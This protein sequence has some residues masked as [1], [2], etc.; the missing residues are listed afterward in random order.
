VTSL[1]DIKNLTTQF[2]THQG[3]V[4]AVNGVS[5]AVGAGEV[6]GIVGE[7]GSGKSVTMLSIMRLVPDP[8]GK[9]VDGQVLFNGRDLLR[10]D[11]A[12]ME[13]VR[14]GEIAMIFQDPMTS[15]NPTWSIGFQLMETLRLRQKMD[16]QQARRRAVELLEMVGIPRVACWVSS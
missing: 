5:L 16:K 8:P 4:R 11:E 1:L 2:H 13:R 15:L 3:T 7:S 14:G 6:V 9:I 10:L 12:E